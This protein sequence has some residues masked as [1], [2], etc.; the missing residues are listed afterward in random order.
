VKESR[1]R[2]TAL[3]TGFEP[4]NGAAL[5]PSQEIVRALGD[6]KFD[7]IQLICEILPCVFSKAG[8]LLIELIEKWKPDVVIALGQ[9][10]GRNQVTPEK[11]AINLDDA[12]IAD[13]AGEQ[14][15]NSRIIENGPDGIFST[16]P[17]DRIISAITGAE[18]PAGASF[19]AGA[20][21]CNNV[22][23]SMQYFLQGSSTLSGFIHV[24]LM[25]EQAKDFPGL[26]TMDLEKMVEAI[27]IAIT[28]ACH[29]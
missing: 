9:A 21:L 17:I 18:I 10:E 22:F 12:R 15:K 2:K 23:Y 25:S 26:P 19:T 1:V 24:P 13:N 7:G 20:F 11:I 28:V 8:P 4:F 27:S 16:L 6:K 3:V 29:S 5:N 14:R